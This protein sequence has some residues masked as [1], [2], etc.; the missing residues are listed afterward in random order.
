MNINPYIGVLLNQ[1]TIN[2]LLKKQKLLKKNL[3][4]YYLVE[5]NKNMNTKLYFFSLKNIDYLQ[6]RIKGTFYNWKKERWEQRH[7]P[8][9]DV[10]YNRVA[11]GLESKTTHIIVFKRKLNELNVKQINPKHD[12]NKWELYEKL[13][14]GR[15]GKIKLPKTVLFQEKESLNNMLKKYT[16]VYV[17]DVK[18]RRGKSVLKITKLNNGQF[19]CKQFTSRVKTITLGNLDETLQYIK[20]IFT[21]KNFIIQQAIQLETYKDAIFDMRAEVQRNGK[22]KLVV[23]GIPVRVAHSNSP[24]TSSRTK[25][26]IFPFKQFFVNKLGYSTK[27]YLD[28]NEKVTTFLENVYRSVEKKY[29]RFGELGI[30]FALD[31]KGNLWLIECNATSGKRAFIQAYDDQSIQNLQGNVLSYAKWLVRTNH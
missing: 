16:S 4:I 20:T 21:K 24:V 12:F 18:G 13:S 9:P 23:A 6:L 29:G 15:R 31:K 27:Q 19:E 14:K 26:N 10:F 17:K 30:D 22:G 3:K 28:F 25:T 1:K 11:K 2:R 8:F 7:F 5:R